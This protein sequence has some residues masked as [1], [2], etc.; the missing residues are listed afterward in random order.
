MSE[1]LDFHLKLARKRFRL[2]AQAHVP[3]DGCTALYGPSGCGKTTL[4]RC[5]V[6]LEKA[7]GHI[8]MGEQQW[9]GDGVKTIPSHQRGVGLVFQHAALFDHLTVFGNLQYGRKRQFDTPY[10][11]ELETIIERCGIGHLLEQQTTNL[12]GGERQR[13]ALARTLAN[14]P[15]LLILDEPL[16]SLD[17]SSKKI[18]CNYWWKL[19]A[20]WQLPIMY[21]SHHVEEIAHIADRVLGIKDGQVAYLKSIQEMMLEHDPDN[22]QSLQAVIECQRV[23]EKQEP[24]LTCLS[25]SGGS[26]RCLN[27]KT[28]QAT[29]VG[30][31]TRAPIAAKDVS[32]ATEKPGPHQSSTSFPPPSARSTPMAQIM[33]AV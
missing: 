23:D 25:F 11:W 33:I 31:R 1:T 20:Q 9:L 19:R 32:I 17:G 2:D 15:R 16:A 5:L 6:G 10:S 26:L 24:G 7:T 30:A 12:S 3:L 22:D 14:A 13:V 4:L 8:R 29:A 28:S 18:S 27:P 21:V